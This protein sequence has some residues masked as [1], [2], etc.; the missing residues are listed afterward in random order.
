[1]DISPLFLGEDAVRYRVFAALYHLGPETDSG[2]YWA[3]LRGEG[4]ERA[5]ANDAVVTHGAR[6]PRGC[7]YG[8]SDAA[9]RVVLVGLERVAAGAASSES[10][11]NNFFAPAAGAAA[12]P[13]PVGR[14]A[15]AAGG[16]AAAARSGTG[17][18]APGPPHARSLN[19][20]ACSGTGRAARL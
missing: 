4:G 9:A 7:R 3:I 14:W 11:R 2:H 13:A 10:E 15:R 6:I 8:D 17:R 20:R 18:A 1:M 5:C 12:G 16:A 19:A